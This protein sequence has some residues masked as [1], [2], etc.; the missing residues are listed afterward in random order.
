MQQRLLGSFKRA[1]GVFTSFS[2]PQRIIAAIGIAVLLLGSVAFYRWASAPTMQPL[3][4]NLAAADASAIVDQLDSQG[5]GYELADSGTSVLVPRDQ[6]YKLRLSMS[7]Q[8]LPASKDTGYALLDQQ[9]VTA[10]QF[11]QQV[12]YQRALEG[13]L[14]TTVKAL[15]GVDSAVVHLAIPTK[16]VFS[17]STDKTTASVL[18]TM[19][20]G[21]EIPGQQVQS[22]VHLV[23]SSVEGMD[24]KDVTVVDGK[25]NLLSTAGS[26]ATSGGL[27]DQQTSE[28][29][30]KVT[31]SLQRVL[32]RVVG[33]GNAVA[34]VTADLSYDDVDRTTETFTPAKGTPPLTETNTSE[35][36]SGNGSAATGVLGPDNIAVPNGTATAKGNNYTKSGDTKTNAVNKVTERTNQAAGSLT[37][38]SVSVVV[39]SSSGAA[40]DMT[41]L[42]D[43]VTAAAGINTKRGDS[44]SVTKMPFDTKSAEA[45]AASAKEAAQAAKRQELMEVGRTGGIILVG[46]IV[47]IVALIM[48]R[49]RVSE[50]VLDLTALEPTSIE[51]A[52]WAPD[53]E[54]AD[55]AALEGQAQTPALE[56]A[57]TAA[58]AQREEVA[59]LVENQPDEVAELL[60]GWLADRRS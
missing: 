18:V 7:S 55:P 12:T 22:I 13:E 24:P 33:S 9:G 56:A 20:P 50:E 31:A 27:R 21:K 41:Q 14:S 28:Y 60:R 16:D 45:A 51:E 54:A 59:Q 57:R 43:A 8:G 2:G 44:I 29:E 34:T 23:S 26:G 11:Q 6:V 36:Y 52:D 35:K 3:F 10:S 37:R 40:V 39:N 53:D 25:G 17:D 5:V 15:D 4:T 49:R 47:A 32:D 1:G 46:L 19:K 42:T 38:Q 30:A 58:S 48:S